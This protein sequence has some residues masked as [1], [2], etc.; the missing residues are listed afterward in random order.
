MQKLY[1]L[2]DSHKITIT[3]GLV[4]A[5]WAYFVLIPSILLLV[6][7]VTELITYFTGPDK[8]IE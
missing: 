1:A 3:V 4:M 7:D 6:K 5:V 2:S 8:V